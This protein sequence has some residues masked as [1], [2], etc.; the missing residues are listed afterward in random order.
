[1]G[2]LQ[3]QRGERPR[4]LAL[5]RRAVDLA[6]EA[7]L[8]WNNLGNVLLRL[9]QADDAEQAFRRSIALAENPEA[10][11]NL[12]RLLRRRGQWHESEAACRRAIDIAPDFGDAWHNLSLVMLAQGR[13]PEG[14]QAASKALT[15][16]PAHK[17][18]RDSYTRALVLLGE[19][20]QAAAIYREWLAEAP[21][22]EYVKH[23]LAACCGGAAPARASDAYVELVFDDFA[24]SFDAKLARLNYR[25]PQLAVDA[26]RAVLPPPARQ[27][28]IADLGCGTGLCGPLVDAWSRHL[29]GCDLSGAMLAQAQ[30]RG[31]YDV[32]EKA[33]LVQYLAA[34]PAGFDVLISADTLC[35][36][37]DLG[38]VAKAARQALHPGGWFVF[39]VE[40]LDAAGPADCRLMPNGRYAHAL[41]HLESVLGAAGFERRRIEGVALRDEGGRPVRG[42]LAT[43]QCAAPLFSTP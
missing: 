11:A 27:F 5:L 18:R 30:R 31:V 10:H 43:G 20:E 16:L 13:V 7:P 41:G 38:E 1:M 3:H 39:T 21:D 8:V 15:L 19:T 17:R 35:Y 33:E 24:E 37:G 9:D 28:N 29:S 40:A 25:A 22:N 4:A 6:P 36:F 14:I 12:S 26:L 2:V 42:W 32:L 34:H 23:H